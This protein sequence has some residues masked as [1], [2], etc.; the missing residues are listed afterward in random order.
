MIVVV[1]IFA[2]VFVIYLLFVYC[3]QLIVDRGIEIFEKNNAE[4]TACDLA[5]SNGHQDIA[6]LLESRMVFAVSGSQSGWV[7]EWVDHRVD[8]SRSGELML[9]NRREFPVLV[10]VCLWLQSGWVTEWVCHRVGGSPSGQVMEWNGSQ[11]RWVTEWVGHRVGG[12]QS[13]W[14]TEWVGH[15]VG[16]SC[17]SFCMYSVLLVKSAQIRGIL[18]C[19]KLFRLPGGLYT[20]VLLVLTVLQCIVYVGLY[21]PL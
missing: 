8:G 16:G 5:M 9:A 15:R 14:V 6:D 20:E 1:L 3:P 12:S 21:W 2:V 4:L 19:V 18:W 13:G 17:N 7:T 11:S 10:I